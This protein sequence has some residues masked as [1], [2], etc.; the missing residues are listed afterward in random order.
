[1]NRKSFTTIA[2]FLGSLAFL[3][4]LSYGSYASIISGEV[5]DENGDPVPDLIVAVKSFKGNFIPERIPE[6]HGVRGRE[7]VFPPPQP[8]NTDATGSFVIKNIVAPSVNH[9]SLFPERNSEYEIRGIEIQ[10]IAFSVHPHQFFMFDGFPFGI[11]EKTDKIN[12]KITVRRRMRIRGQIFK[13]DGSPLRN[14][15]VTLKTKERYVNGGSGSGSGS[16][17]TDDEGRFT[18]YVDRAAYYTITIEYQ[19][20]TAESPE[21]LLE[22]GQRL[23]GL[24]LTLKGV[25]QAPRKPNIFRPQAPPVPRPPPNMEFRRTLSQRRREGVWAV[26]PA[27]RHAYKVISCQ[28]PEEALAIAEEQKA[29]LLA[30]NDQEEQ[31]WLLTVYGKENYWIGFTDG[32]KQDDKKWDSGDPLTYTNWDTQKLLAAPE[33]PAENEESPSKTYTVLIGVTGKWQQV[34]TDNPL[35]NITNKAILE[36]KDLVVGAPTPDEETQ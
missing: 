3:F 20:Q 12:V 5:V 9:L 14:T 2:V 25:Q 26:N 22:E 34:R 32:L 28:S 21:L 10:G 15:R 30:I 33:N 31:Q 19:G 16:T 29:H 7:P 27:N 35:A 23:D 11:E 6:R 36:K 1:M 13:D 24:T 17:Q 18:E 8:S 4:F